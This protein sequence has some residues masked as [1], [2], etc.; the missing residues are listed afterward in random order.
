MPAG[1]ECTPSCGIHPGQ[2]P[3]PGL[4][5]VSSDP[6]EHSRETQG[7]SGG[8][9][10]EEDPGDEWSWDRSSRGG[11]SPP[12]SKGTTWERHLEAIHS[13]ALGSPRPCL[14]TGKEASPREKAGPRVCSEDAA[15]VDSAFSSHHLMACP[16]GGFLTKP[17]LCEILPTPEVRAHFSQAYEN[18]SPWSFSPQRDSGSP[19]LWTTLG[20]RQS[21]KT[22]QNSLD[23]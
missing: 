16:V 5:K 13:V 10:P 12:G 21:E 18:F 1:C 15:P 17:L 23:F 11:T 20:Q 22:E 6:R 8:S 7:T 14:S 4:Q 19:L 3:P 2:K 9:E